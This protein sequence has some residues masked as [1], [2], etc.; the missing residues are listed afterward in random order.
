MVHTL[1]DNY[2]RNI[3]ILRENIKRGMTPSQ[4]TRVIEAWRAQFVAHNLYGDAEKEFINQALEVVS[5]KTHL[6]VV[7]V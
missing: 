7:E 5:K 1:P 6:G 3:K 2:K 4:A